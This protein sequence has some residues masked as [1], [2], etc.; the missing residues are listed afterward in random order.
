LR[1]FAVPGAS[2]GAVA[3]FGRRF[4]RVHDDKLR[5]SDKPVILNLCQHPCRAEEE[6]IYVWCQ[7]LIGGT[8]A[9][10]NFNLLFN[11][12]QLT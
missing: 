7:I 6:S 11:N 10:R 8:K 5:T 1:F 3:D 2:A 9:F 4:T 12:F